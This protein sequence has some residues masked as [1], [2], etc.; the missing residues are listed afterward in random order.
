MSVSFLETSTIDV[1]PRHFP[2]SVGRIT[3]TFDLR[4]QD[5][6]NVSYVIEVDG[7]CFFVKT[8]G[9]PEHHD[10]VREFDQR[11][12]WLR[13]AAE[14]RTSCD[15]PCLPIL[16]HTIESNHGPMLIYEYVEGQLLNSSRTDP[17][18]PY[19]RF[20]SMPSE[21]ILRALDL[22]YEVHAQLSGLGWVM[23]DFYDGAVI[24][25]FQTQAIHLVDLDMYSRGPLTNTSGRWWGSSRFVAPEEF[26]KGAR[27]DDRTSVY[28]LGKTA[29]VFLE[30]TTLSR[31]AFRG[32]DALHNVVSRACRQDPSDRFPSV[33]DFSRAWL[34]ARGT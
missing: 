25:D 32:S 16:H 15:H 30:D 19:N 6:G 24:Y 17:T 3:R 29:A 9:D 13:N 14:L 10:P 23:V 21:K 33:I 2:E 12:K 31:S 11:V 1:D 5:S 22:I 4:T 20:R 18:S 26:E 7:S 28:T 8:A 34:D 27:L